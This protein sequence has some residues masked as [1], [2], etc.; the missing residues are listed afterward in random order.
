MF[1]LAHRLCERAAGA[2]GRR[3][4]RGEAAPS[5][6]GGVVGARGDG[7]R[8]RGLGA[9]LAL[10][11][12]PV[13][14]AV[15]TQRA[16]PAEPA[17]LTPWRL[18]AATGS[19]WGELGLARRLGVLEPG[20]VGLPLGLPRSLGWF[21]VA[22]PE[23]AWCSSMT[24][25]DQEHQR[26]LRSAADRGYPP[27]MAS[28]AHELLV[29][30]DLREQVDPEALR[31]ARRAAAA[32]D[33][34]GRA[35]LAALLCRSG[36]PDEARR[37]LARAGIPR[38]PWLALSRADTCARLGELHEALTIY[39]ELWGRR[40]DPTLTLLRGLAFVAGPME[41]ILADHPEWRRPDDAVLRVE[42][43]DHD[44]RP[45]D[46]AA[47][48]P[49]ITRFEPE[50]VQPLFP[51]RAGVLE[52]GVSQGI[53]HPKDYFVP[54]YLVWARDAARLRAGILGGK[55]HAVRWS[56]QG[57]DLVRVVVQ[58][59]GDDQQGRI[60]GRVLGRSTAGVVVELRRGTLPSG[61]DGELFWQRGHVVAPL[62]VDGEFEVAELP[63]GHYALRLV[64]DGVPGE[65][66]ALELDGAEALIGL[67]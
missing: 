6:R 37:W 11:G 48:L 8:W 36:R 28:L 39:R 47:H 35:V 38:Q 57:E 52:P 31:L 50:A 4:T 55:S 21:G 19:A 33:D 41:S 56:W 3:L 66:Q 16:A 59:W 40:H 44:G 32:G 7:A 62:T 24:A 45:L 17:W 61:R 2:V 20:Q 58:P 64:V 27:A 15:G 53:Y 13:A 63:H 60:R 54:T 49:G 43:Y 42:V 51:I 5:R 22:E 9:S 12:A 30:G 26:L 65:L 10:L 29:R 46:G 1:P 23:P 67:R 14:V 25:R 34:G 18:A